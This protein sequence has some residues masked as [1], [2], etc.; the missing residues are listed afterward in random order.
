MKRLVGHEYGGQI[1]QQ[2]I[3]WSNPWRWMFFLDSHTLR[4]SREGA[5]DHVWSSGNLSAAT[6]FSNWHHVAVTYA[7]S[8]EVRFYIDGV[9]DSVRNMGSGGM[10]GASAPLRI[11]NNAYSSQRLAAY[12]G[13]MA[14][15]NVVR[16]SFPYAQFA[17]ITN[18]PSIAAG[19]VVGPPTP[20]NPDLAVL[21]LNA[22]SNPDGGV[23]VEAVV[24]NQG[25]ETTLNGFYTDVYVDHLPTGEGD[26]N[27]SLEFWVNDPI[28][29]GESVTLRTT[30]ADLGAL[31]ISASARQAPRG[32]GAEY[33]ETTATHCTAQTNSAGSIAEPDDTN[34]IYS[35]G[36]EFC[37][38]SPDIYEDDGAYTGANFML[39]GIPQTHNLDAAGD[40]D[41]VK[42]DATTGGWYQNSTSDL[43]TATDTYLH[44][45]ETD[46]QTLLASNDDAGGGLA[47]QILWQA[48]S[49]GTYYRADRSLE[50][51]CWRLRHADAPSLRDE[52]AHSF[53]CARARQGMDG[54]VGG[55]LLQ[56]GY[57]HG[58]RDEPTSLLPG[59]P[60]DARG[61]GGVCAEGHRRARV[62]AALEP[63]HL[64]GSA[65]GRQGMDGPMGE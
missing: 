12:V 37:V 57:H 55:G 14:L 32:G 54:A 60:G 20:G 8:G 33:T 46:G 27:G 34:N 2:E 65:R 19:A 16:T 13:G 25:D 51:Q 50:P 56:R 47:S 22:F 36:T 40:T 26:F 31:G 17:A 42:F 28:G 43:G 23:I 58:L 29:V 38:A 41:W 59:E 11:G 9:L 4:F 61:D 62:C 52:R 18:E 48:P 6:F 53:G 30:V 5:N 24:Q 3:G 35:E 7:C 45:Y 1:I 64:L 21:S 10:N 49:S 63:S 39:V 44:L 15:S